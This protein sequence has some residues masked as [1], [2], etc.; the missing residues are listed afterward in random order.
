MF[1]VSE[2]IDYSEDRF[3][4]TCNFKMD[5]FDGRYRI[6]LH[7]GREKEYKIVRRFRCSKCKKYHTE[8]PFSITP[9]KHYRTIVIKEVIDG[10]VCEYDKICE[11]GPHE[12]TMNR[13]RRQYRPQ[14]FQLS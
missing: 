2:P 7:Y 3:C 14:D 5:Y 13:W 11:E 12:M 1:R 10:I 9:Y 6:M 4:P 8:I